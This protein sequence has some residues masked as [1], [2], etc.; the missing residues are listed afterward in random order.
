ML[1]RDPLRWGF[2]ANMIERR[3]RVFWE[4][5]IIDT[6]R[7]SPLWFSHIHTIMLRLSQSLESGRPATFR[8]C[9]VDCEFPSDISATMGEGGEIIESG[10]KILLTECYI[11]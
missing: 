6:W 3:R 4:I 9:V 1:D 11:E 2:D 5:Y 8:T 7:V 10:M